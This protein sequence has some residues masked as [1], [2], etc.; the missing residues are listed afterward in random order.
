MITTR[1][2]EQLSQLE[3]LS[4]RQVEAVRRKDLDLLEELDQERRKMLAEL[5]QDDLADLARR[6]P[7][8][9]GERLRRITENDRLAQLGLRAALDELGREM[10]DTGTRH[11]AERAYLKMASHSG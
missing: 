2:E 7:D 5:N 6:Q 1:I 11:R 4:N 10:G 8:L 9:A 3:E